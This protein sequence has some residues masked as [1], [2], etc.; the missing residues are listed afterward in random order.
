MDSRSGSAITDADRSVL[1][2]LAE[3][4]ILIAPQVAQLLGVAESTAAQ[5]LRRLE[6]TGL[7]EY[8]RVF[9]GQPAAAWITRRGLDAI[10]H[11]LPAPRIDLRG[12]R[13][14]VGVGWLWLGAR[15][16][17]FGELAGLTA[18]RE[19]RASDARDGAGIGDLAGREPFGVGLGILT[20]HGQPKRHYPDLVLD[21]RTGHRV[22][23]E[24]ELTAK[25]RGRMSRIMTAY[26]SDARVDAVLYL[27]PTAAIA[28]LVSD[29]ARQAGIADLVHVQ[30]LAPDAIHGAPAHAL[31]RSSGRPHRATRAPTATRASAPEPVR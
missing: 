4:R 31:A 10:E 7:V 20:R 11:P 22:A 12:Y 26:A 25:S 17:V 6:R 24:L 29:A 28:R 21:T 23:V 16:G 18:E 2:P 9:A 13:H 14:D 30:R 27:V 15:E 19:M 8:Q 5:R 1:G 3:H